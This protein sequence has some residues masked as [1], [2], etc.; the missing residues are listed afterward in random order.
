MLKAALFLDYIGE[1]N[2]IIEMEGLK[3]I[4]FS[5]SLYS[6]LKYGIFFS[7]TQTGMATQSPTTFCT[8]F[9]GIEAAYD[10]TFKDDCFSKIIDS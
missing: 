4:I 1:N 10:P 9:P 7:T 5:P 8:M 2:L 6:Y 3:N